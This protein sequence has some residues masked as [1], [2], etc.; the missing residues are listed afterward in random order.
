M[1]S[2]HSRIVRNEADDKVTHRWKNYNIATHGVLWECGVIVGIK[3]L[4]VNVVR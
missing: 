4:G 1:E 3:S 2:P